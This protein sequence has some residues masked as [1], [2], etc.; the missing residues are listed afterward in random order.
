MIEKK[1]SAKHIPQIV[2]LIPSLAG[3]VGTVMGRLAGGVSKNECSVE[4]WTISNECDLDVEELEEN[5][6]LVSFNASR[7]LFALPKIL[8]RLNQQQPDV[9]LST[10]FHINCIILFAQA[11]LN[12]KTKLFISEHTALLDALDSVGRAKKFIISKLIKTL[13]PKADG[14]IGISDT[15]ARQIEKVAGLPAQSVNRIYNPVISS[16]I[17]AKSRQDVAHP[18]FET[19]LPVILGVGRLS[20][21]K[22]F[23]NLIE[24]FY[25]VQRE[26]PA[27]LLI[28]GDG[29]ERLALE[30]L[31][32]ERH[33]KTC[34]SFAGYVKNPYPYFSKADLFVLSSLREGL[35]TVL[36]EALALNVPVVST[37][38]AS[39]AHEILKNG[40]LGTL[41][42]TGNP[43]QLAQGILNALKSPKK[44]HNKALLEY[45]VA[46]ASKAY[47]NYLLPE[48]AC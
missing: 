25:L 38:T 18:F 48:R 9:I 40:K 31:V 22:D 46:F 5:I 45:D 36:I 41:V 24:A 12:T 27:Q 42:P 20:P 23:T 6:K 4:I 30:R 1:H 8:W 44:V 2:F 34:T 33:I 16:A 32:Q 10:S 17:H 14:W 47:I 39:G 15:I 37:D 19:G 11:L 43:E 7:A 35:P 3:G 26:I 13:Y 28:L 29:P 21:E